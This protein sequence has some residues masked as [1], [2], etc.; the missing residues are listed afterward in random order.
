MSAATTVPEFESLFERKTP[1]EVKLLLDQHLEGGDNKEVEKYGNVTTGDAKG[2]DAV[3][4]AFN[5]LLS[6]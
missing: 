5:D 6:N 4:S 1:E 2:L 3:E